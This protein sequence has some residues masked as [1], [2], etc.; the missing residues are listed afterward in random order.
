M[1]NKI[2]LLFTDKNT[3]ENTTATW[4]PYA[5]PDSMKAVSIVPGLFGFQVTG[6]TK[7]KEIL[8]AQIL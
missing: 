1:A 3:S 5:A 7:G 6:I 8:L 4:L 2:P